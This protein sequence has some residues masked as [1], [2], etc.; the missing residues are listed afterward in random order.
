LKPKYIISDRGKEFD[1]AV[2]KG[3]CRRKG[4]RPRYG[5]VGE[6]GSIA[7]VERFIRSMKSECARRITVP[8]S[9]DEMRYEIG[10]YATW[11]NLYRVLSIYRTANSSPSNQ[12]FSAS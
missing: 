2:F 4:I 10:S 5:A 8:F 7:I 1:C 12:R 9:L 6:H 11:F 3:W